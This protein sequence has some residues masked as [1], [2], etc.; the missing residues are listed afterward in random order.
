MSRRG[1]GPAGHRFHIPSIPGHGRGL[2][3]RCELSV[4]AWDDCLTRSAEMVV[5]VSAIITNSNLLW[6]SLRLHVLAHPWLAGQLRVSAD[7]W[8]PHSPGCFPPCMG[9]TSLSY[10]ETSAGAT[11]MTLSRSA[12]RHG[13]GLH[14]R[15]RFEGALYSGASSAKTKSHALQNDTP[16]ARRPPGYEKLVPQ[17]ASFIIRTTP[18]LVLFGSFVHITNRAC[19]KSL[20]TFVS[21]PNVKHVQLVAKDL[22]STS[23]TP[24]RVTSQFGVRMIQKRQSEEACLSLPAASQ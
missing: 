10:L 1:N 4:V 7:R 2:I 16:Q 23:I 9:Y 5:T 20:L 6:R 8:R 22:S 14:V 12:I 15:H 21:Q 13:S 19:A 18:G 17:E 24:P 11:R 3:A